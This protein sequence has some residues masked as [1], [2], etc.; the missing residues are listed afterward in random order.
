M[1]KKSTDKPKRTITK[2]QLSHLQR[3][4]RR[5]RIILTLGITVIVAVVALVTVGVY[6]QWY[7]PEEKPMGETVL[8][9][10]GATFDMRYFIDAL[11]FQLGDYT[12]LAEYYLDYTL[13]LMEQYEL[14]IQG[15]NGLGYSVTQ[16]EID[17]QLAGTGYEDNPAARDVVKASLLMQQLSEDYFRLQLPVNPEQRH[18]MAM[19][20]E[21]QAQADEVTQRLA[22]GESFGDIAAELSLDST[23]KEDSGD[24]G[25]YPEGVLPSILG[26]TVLDEAI[27]QSP[28][29][30]LSQAI[31]DEDRIK[32]LG[33]WL[34]KV[35]GME[36]DTEGGLIADVQAILV[37]SEQEAEEVL[38]RLDDGEDFAELAEEYSQ[39][40]TSGERADIGQIVEGD[41]TEAFENYVF[42]D[43]TQVGAVSPPIADT[44]TSTTG[45]YWLFRVE[46]SENREISEDDQD[47]LISLAMGDWIQAM[48]DDPNTVINTYLDDEKRDF[49]VNKVTGS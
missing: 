48:Q 17:E 40:G 25:W 35:I 15:A 8:E 44:E 11:N 38:N 49:T 41:M 24:L 16:D 32:D 12:Y 23:T 14:V 21:S 45:G 18:M 43:D 33:Y 1:A 19:F 20:L 5:H 4:K 7:L 37:S 42:A 27:F 22:N 39:Y 2:R 3:Q 28:V 31:Y 6:F 9:V 13:Q 34:I 46:A 10:N 26:T 29:G 47:I 30:Q 36:E